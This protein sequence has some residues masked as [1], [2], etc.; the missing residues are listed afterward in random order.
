MLLTAD[1]M[2]S[3]SSAEDSDQDQDGTVLTGSFLRVKRVKWLKKKFRDSFHAIDKA[4]YSSHK[5]SKDKLKRRVY[6]GFSN[7]QQPLN[8]PKFAIRSE[9]RR[10]SEPLSD[11]IS[12]NSL[13][14]PSHSH[15]AVSDDHESPVPVSSP[16]SESLIPNDRD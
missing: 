12:N 11:E 10:D 6:N 9:F 7:R 15:S 3:E 1:Y 8:A 16:P 2:S 13:S 14:S 5:Q 4:Y